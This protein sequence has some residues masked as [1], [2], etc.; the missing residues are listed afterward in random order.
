M[1]AAQEG[2]GGGHGAL[3]GPSAC[4]LG[5]RSCCWL[6]KEQVKEA[7]PGT[8]S[9]NKDRPCM[10]LVSPEIWVSS[11]SMFFDSFPQLTVRYLLN[12]ATALHG[13]CQVWG[14]QALSPLPCLHVE[15]DTLR[16]H[17]YGHTRPRGTHTRVH[18]ARRRVTGPQRRLCHTL[19]ARA[20]RDTVNAADVPL[21]TPCDGGDKSLC[22]WCPWTQILAEPSGVRV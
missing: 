3:L 8:G 14:L 21:P 13:D 2:A 17:T 15:A 7:G 19:P 10:E 6:E 4:A 5:A 12:L 9:H 20:L 11:F 16:T 18:G 22:I 1:R